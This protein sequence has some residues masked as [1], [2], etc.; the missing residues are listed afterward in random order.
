M[1]IQVGDPTCCCVVKI[2]VGILQ[3]LLLRSENPG[4]DTPVLWLRVLNPGRIPQVL[5][6]GE[7]HGW[8]TSSFVAAW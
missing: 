2:P 3:V 5:W 6:R 7:D 8:D 1:K 4:W